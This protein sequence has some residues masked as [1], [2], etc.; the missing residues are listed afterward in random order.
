[1]KLTRDQITQ[2][3][4]N[5]NVDSYNLSNN[6][7]S[8]HNN[9]TKNI[10]EYVKQLSQDYKTENNSYVDTITRET[11]KLAEQMKELGD[12]LAHPAHLE[13]WFIDKQEV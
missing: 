10:K 13:V 1:M 6:F 9:H 7:W 8:T 4:N 12:L 11:E 3:V 2:E 5:F